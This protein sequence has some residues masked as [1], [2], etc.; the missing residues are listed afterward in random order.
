MTMRRLSFGSGLV[1]SVAVIGAILVTPAAAKKKPPPPPP[2]PPPSTSSL[3]VKSYADVI[4]GVK[5]DLT[6]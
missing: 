5:C 2:P 1:L 3:Y 6:A 4:G